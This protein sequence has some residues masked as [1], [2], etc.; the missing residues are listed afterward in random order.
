MAEGGFS[1]I[2]DEHVR[3]YASD[4]YVLVRGGFDN[5]VTAD[6]LE[7]I[8]RICAEADPR[9]EKACEGTVF[10]PERA[11]VRMQLP[12]ASKLHCFDDLCIPLALHG[13]V[14]SFLISH[15]NLINHSC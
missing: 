3:R 15:W 8:D 4:G 11:S 5:V 12:N 7:A 9:F 10:D 13:F 2:T 6:A 1:C 14:L